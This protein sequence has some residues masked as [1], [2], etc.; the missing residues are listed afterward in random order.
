[1]RTSVRYSSCR[2]VDSTWPIFSI[3]P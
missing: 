1:L 3:R 2:S